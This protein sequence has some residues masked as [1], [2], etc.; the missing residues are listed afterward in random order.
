MNK[1]D[2]ITDGWSMWYNRAFLLIR[3]LYKGGS[4]IFIFFFT[5]NTLYTYEIFKLNLSPAANSSQSMTEP[6]RNTVHRNIPSI[7]TG[8]RAFLKSCSKM[9]YEYKNIP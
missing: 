3:I 1:L 4:F 2:Y 7:N 9:P 6:R 5:Q 8:T